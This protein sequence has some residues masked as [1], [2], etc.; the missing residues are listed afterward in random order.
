MRSGNITIAYCVAN[1]VVRL[2][3][4]E[5]VTDCLWVCESLNWKTKAIISEKGMYCTQKW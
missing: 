2:D 1:G 3:M 5:W 4:N